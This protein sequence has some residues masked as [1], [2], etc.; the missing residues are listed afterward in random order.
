MQSF[1]EMEEEAIQKGKAVGH[2]RM[3][4]AALSKKTNSQ[5][6]DVM[7]DESIF[8]HYI[9]SVNQHQQQRQ[10]AFPTFLLLNQIFP[11][12]QAISY[13]AHILVTSFCCWGIVCGR[14]KIVKSPSFFHVYGLILIIIFS[15]QI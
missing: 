1:G 11:L 6:A 2:W 15:G 8:P 12:A 13:L 4:S 5:T 7:I 14:G 9:P 3:K 10:I